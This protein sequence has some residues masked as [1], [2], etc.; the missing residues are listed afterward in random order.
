M[1]DLS[2][3]LG[4]VQAFAPA[5][6]AATTAGSA[7]DLLGF[8]SAMLTINTGAIAGSGLYVVSLDESDVSGSGY[9]AVA[10]ADMI[11]TLPASLAADSVYKVSYI[12]NK[13]FVKATI[14]KTSGTSIAAGAVIV[15]GHASSRPVA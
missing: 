7:I 14:T 11:G 13:R 15:K 1:R 10:A 3:N 6:Y 8:D 12:G 5:V 9:T 2:H 4:V